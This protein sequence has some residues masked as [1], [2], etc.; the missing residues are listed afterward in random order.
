MLFF[1]TDLI[2]LGRFK[3]LYFLRRG[4]LFWELIDLS[5]WLILFSMEIFYSE[6]QALGVKIL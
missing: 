5:I 2:C 6:I 1:V 3:T 4:Y